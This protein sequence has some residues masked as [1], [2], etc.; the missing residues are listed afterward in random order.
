MGLSSTTW[1][2]IAVIALLLGA[3]LLFFD[4]SRGGGGGAKDRRRWAAMRGWEYLDTDPVLPSRWRYG[5]IHQGG[6]GVARNLISGDVPTPDGPRQAY[7]FDHEQAG[8]LNSV[9]VAVQVQ[10]QLPA[11]VELRLPSAPLPDDAGLDLLEP[12]GERYA[13]V[14]DAEAVRPLLTSRLADA[15]DA[16]G[17][18]VELLWAEESWV[19]ATAPLDS[20]PERLQDLLADLAEVATALEQGQNARHRLDK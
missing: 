14:S 16:V 11:A 6:P 15:S 9:L 13:F 3:A 19:L 8:R 5:T 20:S 2:V 1:F 12:V 4:R 17:D 18:D 7:V 10:S